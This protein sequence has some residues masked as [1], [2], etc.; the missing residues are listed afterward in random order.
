MWF[1]VST[2]IVTQLLFVTGYLF[3]IKVFFNRLSN[4]EKSNDN[5]L[6]NDQNEKKDFF[7]FFN[8]TVIFVYLIMSKAVLYNGWRQVYFLNVFIIYFT[9]YG[10][11]SLVENISFVKKFSKYF[12]TL[13]VFSLILIF[14]SIYKYHPYQSLYFN[15]FSKNNAQ[16]K[17]EVDY[18]GLSGKKFLND[19]IQ[20]QKNERIKIGVASWVPL[21]RSLALLDKTFKDRIIIVGQDYENADYI[22]SNNITEVNSTLNKKYQIPKNFKKIGEFV[23]EKILIYEVYKKKI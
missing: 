8:L 21:E 11:I 12:Y 9:S 15:N 5:N 1:S 4:I 6:W 17:F 2:P 3:Y 23:I 16:T 14:Y 18:W 20:T 13:I 10:I 7:I 19:I 22:F